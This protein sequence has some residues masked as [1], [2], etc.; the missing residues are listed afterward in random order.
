MNVLLYGVAAI[1]AL[2][3]ALAIAACVRHLFAR[4]VPTPPHLPAISILK[5]VRGLEPG[6]AEAIASN[7]NQHYP[8]FELLFGVA[9]QRDPA[10]REIRLLMERHPEL[11][12]RILPSATRT[13]NRKA[14]VLMDCAAAAQHPVLVVTD[15]DIRVPPD[16]LETLAAELAQTDTGLVTC[17]YRAESATLPGRWEAL[18][19]MTDFIPS[20][21]LA[22]LLS[23]SEFG[24]GA[25]LAFRREHLDRIGGFG[26]IADYLADDYQ[27]G[28]KLHAL[29]LRNVIS[30]VVV[31]T[32]LD[33]ARWRDAWRH[34]VRWARTIRV[35]RSAGYAGLPVTFASLWGLVALASGH[36]RLAAGLIALRLAMAIAAGWFVLR[37]ADVVR[38]WFLIPLRDLWGVGVWTAGLSG[39]TVEWGGRKLTLDRSGRIRS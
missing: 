12:I 29:G 21:L 34:Q 19:V 17:V 9:D 30:K 37:S 36:P 11:P 33:A 23:V 24:L 26:A 38:Y 8:C 22:P 32:R 20:T 15:A 16:Y 35:S 1:A 10:L 28:C 18:G 13:P 4:R 3:Q 27:L 14:G 25:T 39:N 6:F 7:A 31:S 5:P 2:Y